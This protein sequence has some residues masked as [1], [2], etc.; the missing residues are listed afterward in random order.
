MKN[1]D[2]IA[3]FATPPGNGSIGIIRISGILT[4]KVAFLILKK[5]PSNRLAEYL[6]FYD[7]NGKLI[8]KGIA[9]FFAKPNSYT[10][11]DVLELQGHG[12]QIVLDILLT[13]VISIK[14]IRIA[15]PG[16]FSERAFINEKI[17]LIQAEAIYDIINA[18]STA[19]VKCAINSIKGDFSLYINNI[20]KIINKLRIRIE[21]SID[22]SDHNIDVINLNEIQDNINYIISLIN[23]L[24]IE[25]NNGI[26]LREGMNIVIVG[27]SNVGK[28][29]LFNLLSKKEVSIVTE[30]KG[31]TRDIIHEYINIDGLVINLIDTAGIRYTKNKIEK[32]G[33]SKTWNEIKNADHILYVYD[34]NQKKHISNNEIFKKIKKIIKFSNKITIIFNKSDINKKQICIQKTK[35]NN[36]IYTVIN[37]STKYNIELG[38]NILKNHLKKILL[39]KTTDEGIYISRRRHFYF[40]EKSYICLLN[41]KNHI[42]NNNAYELIAEEL[43]LSH[44]YL[45]K[46]L[47][48]FKSNNLIKDIFSKFCIGK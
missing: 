47:G 38:I 42:Q 28:S 21:A 23:K 37:L 45:N 1:L 46:I 5:I 35:I 27:D 48:K 10:G 41:C 43:M 34:S 25:S 31:T 3:A 20:L 30:I 2:T 15:N 29:S 26:V 4:K 22:F 39:H 9:I 19:A 24:K 14:G 33:I 12:G 40:L 8:D 7:L 11:E 6:S 13:C 16:E 18:N 44:K 32:I 36:K 17:D